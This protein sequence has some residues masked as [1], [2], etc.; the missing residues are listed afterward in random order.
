MNKT[1]FLVSIVLAFCFTNSY[2][3]TPIKPRNTAYESLDSIISNLYS[4]ISGDTTMVRNTEFIKSL[5]YKDAR[6]IYFNN[7]KVNPKLWTKSIDEYLRDVAEYFKKNNF[8]EREIFRKTDTFGPITQVFSTY[9]SSESDDKK[10]KP[11]AKG[12]NSIQLL[13]D[14]K[15]WWVI[16]LYWADDKNTE[17]IP[18]EFLPK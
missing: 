16:S 18:K 8:Y 5:F 1:T 2:A 11:F 9:E 12:I 17:P 6:L 7:D 4:S 13:N 3:Q 15:R 14:G 10:V